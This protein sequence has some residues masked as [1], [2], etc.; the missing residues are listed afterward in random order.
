MTSE[1]ADTDTGAALMSMLS[2]RIDMR[3]YLSAGEDQLSAVQR[4][5]RQVQQ[6]LRTGTLG[7]W[8]DSHFVIYYH[9]GR[10]Q[11]PESA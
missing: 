7:Q 2:L 10:V 6:A 11:Q 4:S 9:D 8:S 5:R 3:D 1:V